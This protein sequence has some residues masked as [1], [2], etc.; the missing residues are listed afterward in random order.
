MPSA[1]LAVRL[2]VIAGVLATAAPAHA[3]FDVADLYLR[4]IRVG[5]KTFFADSGWQRWRTRN[6]FF[7]ETDLI[8]GAGSGDPRRVRP[9]S[10]GAALTGFSVGDIVLLSEARSPYQLTFFSLHS[11]NFQ[12]GE[13]AGFAPL[14]FLAMPMVGSEGTVLYQGLT[15]FQ[16][17]LG[18]WV[19]GA[20]GVLVD[21]S[22]GSPNLNSFFQANLP[23]AFFQSSAVLAPAS[24]QVE[25]LQFGFRYDE[26]TWMNYAEVGRLVQ[27]Y[28]GERTFYYAGIDGAWNALTVEGRVS[29]QFE[30][31]YVRAGLHRTSEGHGDK[32][33]LAKFG[34]AWDIKALL[35]VVNPSVANQWGV[36]GGDSE[37]HF[38]GVLEFTYQAPATKF[39]GFFMLMMGA[40]AAALTED[41]EESDRT[42]EDSVRVASAMIENSREDEALYCGVTVGLSYNDPMLLREVPGAVDHGRIYILGRAFF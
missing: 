8:L 20:Y 3:S 10:E 37:L 15:G 34:S 31:A 17:R 39:M 16:V 23:I 21:M 27:N 11:M 40:Q 32:D 13:L 41:K 12:A 7:Y 24:G 5:D 38:G 25:R 6:D 33:S 22:Q 2:A 9:D 26:A 4:K 19:E 28:G 29:D 42:I 18:K 30:L 14:L 1:S 35:T 36:G